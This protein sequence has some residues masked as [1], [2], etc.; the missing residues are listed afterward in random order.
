MTPQEQ[1][2]AAAKKALALLEPFRDQPSAK[3]SVDAFGDL[4][5][6]IIR[7]EAK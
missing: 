7:A 3:E 4:L 6:A 5:A 1:L 2:L